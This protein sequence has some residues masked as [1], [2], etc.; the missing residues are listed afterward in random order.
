MCGILG[1]IP[2]ID[3]ACFSKALATLRHRGPDASCVFHNDSI[4]LGHARLSILDLDFRAL[5]PMH[6]PLHP[7]DSGENMA[8]ALRAAS[9]ESKTNQLNINLNP[10]H[11][12]K[13]SLVFNGEIYNFI[14]LRSQL[15]S[16]GY[17]FHTD[18]DSEVVI[19]SFDAWGV[20]CLNRFNGAWAIALVDHINGRLLLSRDRFGKKP[21][22]YAFIKDPRG[23][24]RFV[25]ASEMK[26]IYPFLPRLLPNSNFKQLTSIGGI[27]NYENTEKTLINGIYRFPKAHFA[28]VDLAS[29]AKAGRLE[30]SRYYHLLDN[31]K[32]DPRNPKPYDEA[33]KEFRDLFLDSV[34]IR[35]RSDVRIGT[36]LSGGLDSSITLGALSYLSKSLAD[37]PRLANDW[38]HAC[39]ACFE[40]TPLDESAYA[41][42]VCDHLGVTGEFLEINPLA[43]WH[44]LEEYFY[45]FEDLY[46]T[47]PVPMVATYGAISRRGVR[48]TIDGHGADELFSGY[49]HINMA[50]WDA[51]LNPRKMLEILRT[52]NDTRENPKSNLS[53]Y[54]EGLRFILKSISRKI[55]GKF[56][57]VKEDHPNF[58]KLD[59]FSKCLYEI[60]DRTILPTLLRNYDRYSMINSVE[61]R[62]PFLDHRL[63][64]FVFSMPYYYKLR[65]GWTKSLMRDGLGDLIPESIA[66]RKSKIGFNSPIIQW[67]QKSSKDGG[68][69][70]WFLDIS[71]SKDFLNCDLIESPSATSDLILKICNGEENS[72]ASGEVLWCGI[73]PYLWQKSLNLATRF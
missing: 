2:A 45:L 36:A 37:K 46:I 5:Q 24:D 28:L 62:M 3:D 47:S 6:F 13:Y 71:R 12:P 54:K 19:A 70:E 25:F 31:L 22:F 1:T 48:V 10:K 41:R 44:R 57:L 59:Y 34:A 63:V 52:L 68:L 66:R 40:G 42:A 58:S 33:T 64:E 56:P 69:K 30:T 26:A 21:L 16:K 8:M 23:V 20:D 35:M 38:Q 17:V 18:S 27:F 39:V 60:F 4:S 32:G 7:L 65:N 29:I 43:H 73:N 49:G 51:K 72:F 9:L 55:R 11:N 50:L 61:I 15:I 14:E 67:M 53:L